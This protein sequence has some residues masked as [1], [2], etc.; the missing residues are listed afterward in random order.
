MLFYFVI[1]Q[2]S[3]RC[4]FN[5]FV[6]L[7]MWHSLMH[8]HHP[9]QLVIAEKIS[10]IE[11]MVFINIEIMVFKCL[12]YIINILHFVLSLCLWYMIQYLTTSDLFPCFPRT[13]TEQSTPSDLFR[14]NFSITV[15]FSP[16][17]L[18]RCLPSNIQ[19]L[20]AL[21]CDFGKASP[22]T[23][24]K[25]PFFAQFNRILRR[26]PRNSREWISM[27]ISSPFSNSRRSY[28]SKRVL[29]G[30]GFVFLYSAF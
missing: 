25:Q 23:N 3:T 28:G 16:S 22:N 4:I 20:T 26:L 30:D 15:G 2:V 1:F 6:K 7:A 11:T 8:A 14:L 29:K 5:S 18:P 21:F 17:P 27:E 19:S 12:A 24:T 9:Q 13:V 10:Y